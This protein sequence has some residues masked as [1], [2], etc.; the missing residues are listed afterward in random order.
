MSVSPICPPTL[1]SGIASAAAP[2]E[3]SKDATLAESGLFFCS[4]CLQTF[5]VRYT[6]VRMTGALSAAK[7]CNEPVAASGISRYREE[8]SQAGLKLWL[9]WDPVA[10]VGGMA[11]NGSRHTNIKFPQL[12]VCVF[13]FIT[14]C[15]DIP[16][17]LARDFG[18]SFRTAHG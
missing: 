17:T 3:R 16:L 14:T 8:S 12:C 6:F 15:R 9:A 5:L 10:W 11:R 13:C 2:A 4:N 1:R 18:K 7:R